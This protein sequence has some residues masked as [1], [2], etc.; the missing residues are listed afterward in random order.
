MA[1]ITK[2]DMLDA[3]NKTLENHH[4]G[5]MSCILDFIRNLPGDPPIDIPETQVIAKS[6]KL[7]IKK[8]DPKKDKIH[9][10]MLKEFEERISKDIGHRF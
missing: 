1:A 3:Y 5:V 4:T 6:K 7:T 2:Q 8:N 9:E 10:D